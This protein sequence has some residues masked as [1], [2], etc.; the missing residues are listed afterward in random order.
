LRI[1]RDSVW[2]AYVGDIAEIEDWSSG[3]TI[4]IFFRQE[5]VEAPV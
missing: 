2:V 1:P 4:S 5:I 3:E